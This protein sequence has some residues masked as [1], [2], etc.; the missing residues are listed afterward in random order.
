MTFVPFSDGAV[1]PAQAP[2]SQ[3]AR[4]LLKAAT[5]LFVYEPRHSRTEI[6]VYEELALQLARTTPVEDRAEAARLLAPHPDAPAAVLALFAADD[7]AVAAPV[8]TGAPGL[9][10]ITLLALVAG[11]SPEHLALIAR[12][13]KLSADLIEALVRK[14]P[15]DRLPALIANAA[16]RLPANVVADLIEAARGRPDL[17]AALARRRED[18]EDADLTDLFL[19]L[20]DRGRRRVLQAL[21]LL[22]LRD[23]AARRPAPRTP[24]PDPEAVA[25]LARAALSRDVGR[26]GGRLAV[27]TGLPDSVARRLVL[28]PGGEPLAIALRAAGLDAATATRVILFSGGG[29]G[30]D[31]F[32]V[33]RLVEL[34]ETLSLR[35]AALLTARWRG[36]AGPLPARP[37]RYVPQTEAG[38][39]VRPREPMPARPEVVPAARQVG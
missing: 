3:R 34:F 20:D 27:V 24:E 23:F 25:D 2:D 31:Y 14:L 8:L 18:V 33:K 12:R 38:T 39:P 36:E 37:P 11:A 10:E 5:E 17:A 7:P 26:L 32:Q 16:I 29:E 28:D 4:T 19:D 9:S 30:R 13:P 22:A 15:P 35:S 21:E 1:R 6:A